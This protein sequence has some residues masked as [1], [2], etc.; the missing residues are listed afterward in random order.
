MG[1]P[2]SVLPIYLD[3]EQ[4]LCCTGDDPQQYCN[5]MLIPLLGLDLNTHKVDN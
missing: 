2:C 4:P 3:T 5:I 1:V